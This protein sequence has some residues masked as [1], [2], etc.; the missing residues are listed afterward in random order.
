MNLKDKV[1]LYNLMLAGL[2]KGVKLAAV[3]AQHGDDESRQ[4]IEAK[5][6]QLAK[7]AASLRKGIQL[8]WNGR[9]TEL[10]EQIR[11]HNTRLQ[12][13]IRDIEKQIKT[14]ERVVKALGYIDDLIAL[15]R[16]LLAG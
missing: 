6:E 2:S 14:A 8:K 16:K 4:L 11:S 12:D 9:A 15:A 5:N 3:L 7:Q 10:R 13:Q 1:D